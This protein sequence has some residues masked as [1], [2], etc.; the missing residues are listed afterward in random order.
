MLIAPLRK[1]RERERERE[2]EGEEERARRVAERG[3]GRDRGTLDEVAVTLRL[4][5]LI[6]W[7]PGRV[8]KKRS[9]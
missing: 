4:V 7:D 1:E 9:F 5:F 3:R 2:R 8:Q 6:T